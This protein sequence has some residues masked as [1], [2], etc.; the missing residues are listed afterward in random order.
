MVR[1]IMRDVAFLSQVSEPVTAENLQVADDLLETLI[2][3][4]DGCVGMAVNVIG[5]NK[6]IIAFDDDGEYMVMFNPEILKKSSPYEAEEGYCLWTVRARPSA[7]SPLRCGIKMPYLAGM[8]TDASFTDVQTYI[9]GGNILLDTDLSAL[10]TAERIHTVV[11]DRLSTDLAVILKT[12]E[13]LAATTQE[14][15]FGASSAQRAESKMRCQ[16]SIRIRLL[17]KQRIMPE[18]EKAMGGVIL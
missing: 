17:E 5:V 18:E 1:K 10:E 8:L 16:C 11:A 12:Q 14:N 2:T 13:R 7:G 15:P 6:R 4:K 3:H 9:Q